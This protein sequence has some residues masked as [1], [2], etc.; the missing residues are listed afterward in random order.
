VKIANKRLTHQ[1]RANGDSYFSVDNI[2]NALSFVKKTIDEESGN[3]EKCF[4]TLIELEK[5]L[6]SELRYIKKIKN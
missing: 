4:N 3:D 6:T 5:C 2:L 1:S